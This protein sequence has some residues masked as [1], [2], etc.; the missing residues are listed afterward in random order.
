MEHLFVSC[1]FSQTIWQLLSQWCH[2]SS[3][4]A[5][6]FHDLLQLHQSFSRSN[7]QRKVYQIVI[8]TVLWSLWRTRNN[9]VFNNKQ[10]HIAAVIEESNALSFLWVKYR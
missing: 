5:F 1:Q 8:L 10:P 2:V 7:K 9:V 3:I 6:H 4:Y